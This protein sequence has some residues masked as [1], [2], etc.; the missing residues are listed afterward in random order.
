MNYCISDHIGSMRDAAKET[1]V[2]RDLR[3]MAEEEAFHKIHSFLVTRN[4][5]R[6]YVKVRVGLLLANRALRSR[7]HFR[8]I[9]SL[10]PSISDSSTAEFW[11][12]S[13][14]PRLGIRRFL[15]Q[16]IFM[17][18]EHPQFVERV[19]YWLQ[20]R[21]SHLCRRAD[22]SAKLETISQRVRE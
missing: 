7:S 9:L 13:V 22:L 5:M 6:D 16:L 21:H 4:T 17:A 8:A 15:D 12:H 1:E 19:L 10:G 18:S 11:I 3:A 14:V 2:V 20:G